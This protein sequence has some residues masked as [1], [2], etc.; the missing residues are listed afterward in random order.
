MFHEELIEVFL[1][2]GDGSLVQRWWRI[3]AILIINLGE[4]FLQKMHH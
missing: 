2:L 4:K 1:E 3:C